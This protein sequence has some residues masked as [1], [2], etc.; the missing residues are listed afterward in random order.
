MIDPTSGSTTPSSPSLARTV[1][2]IPDVLPLVFEH[3]DDKHDLGS[4]SHVCKEW[5]DP[6]Q[7]ELYSSI[8]MG[9]GPDYDFAVDIAALVGSARLRSYVREV[10]ARLGPAEIFSV[11]ALFSRLKYLTLRGLPNFWTPLT[12]LALGSL[13]Q[14][15]SFTLIATG[16]PDELTTIDGSAFAQLVGS[17]TRLRIVGLAGVCFDQGDWTERFTGPA[18]LERLT[19]KR[20]VLRDSEL[21]WLVSSCGHSLIE[22]HFLELPPSMTSAKHTSITR[23]NPACLLASVAHAPHLRALHLWTSALTPTT[24]GRMLVAVPRLTEL[25][26]PFGLLESPGIERAPRPLARLRLVPAARPWDPQDP[27]HPAW[28]AL[29]RLEACSLNGLRE[30]IIEEALRDNVE[31]EKAMTAALHSFAESEG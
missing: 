31:G 9:V 16:Q 26:L 5:A 22:F 4:A 14:I 10:R 20:S 11:A 28:W 18:H 21:E 29:E 8:E 1:R 19:V 30:L 3:L 23:V 27:I 7:L 2:L 17:W 24:L 15:E 25:T 12:V 13:G 6:A